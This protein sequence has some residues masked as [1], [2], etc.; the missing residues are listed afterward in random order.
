M[1]HRLGNTKSKIN[2]INAGK[3]VKQGRGLE[4]HIK[5]DCTAFRPYF[6]NVRI[7]LLENLT[8]S[9]ESLR[10]AIHQEGPFYPFTPN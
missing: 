2:A 7:N 6:K 1:T 8:T 3:E 9:E 4:K 10:S 5:K